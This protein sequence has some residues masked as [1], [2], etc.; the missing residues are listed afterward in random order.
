MQ[1]Y[2][3]TPVCRE[4]APN[5]KEL[6][7][8][9]YYSISFFAVS[10]FTSA[11]FNSSH[12]VIMRWHIYIAGNSCLRNC[13]RMWDKH[14]VFDTIS[15]IKSSHIHKQRFPQIPTCSFWN[16]FW[17]KLFMLLTHSALPQTPCLSER[18]DV[19]CVFMSECVCVCL[20]SA[21]QK[22]AAGAFVWVNY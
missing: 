22:G 18:I 14:L 20:L 1:T 11:A 19:K 5:V 13:G 9:S 15:T 16:Y 8:C 4:K 2:W 17:M 12:W 3:I 7:K 21:H 6:Q 10:H